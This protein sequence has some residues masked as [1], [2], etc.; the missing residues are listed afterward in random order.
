MTKSKRDTIRR[1]W[2]ILLMMIAEV[3]QSSKKPPE[4]T[5]GI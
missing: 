3:E 2:G 4:V 5:G 1:E